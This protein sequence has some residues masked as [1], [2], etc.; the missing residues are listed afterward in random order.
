MEILVEADP[1]INPL[2]RQLLKANT[3]NKMPPFPLEG[4]LGP[5]IQENDSA[6]IRAEHA[7]L[8]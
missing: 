1:T 7:S 6:A 3:G 2:T 8:S 4:R 5:W